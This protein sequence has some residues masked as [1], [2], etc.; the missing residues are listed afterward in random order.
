MS[1]V[2]C[3]LYT[4]PTFYAYF[5]NQLSIS[6]HKEKYNY[7]NIKIWWSSIAFINFRVWE[8]RQKKQLMNVILL[9]SLWTIDT[10]QQSTHRQGLIHLYH[11]CNGVPQTGKKRS[12]DRLV[13]LDVIRMVFFGIKNAQS[14]AARFYGYE[15]IGRNG[16]S[17]PK[18]W[19]TCHHD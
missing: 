13:F 5:V 17:K 18:S 15:I 10:T 6:Q 11:L 8:N 2:A 14:Q 19:N 1:R 9:R 7:E 4:K 16:N 12:N 3:S